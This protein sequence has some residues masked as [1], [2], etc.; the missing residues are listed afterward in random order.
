M[1]DYTQLDDFLFEIG[2]PDE[3]P[4][5]SRA[6]AS[7]FFV[8]LKKF[9]QE[10]VAAPDV[11][12]QLEGQFAVPLDQAVQ[13]IAQVISHELKMHAAYLYYS[14][15]VRS[16]AHRSLE[17]LFLQHA[18]GELRDAEYLLRRLG[19]LVPGGVPLP[20]PP[21]PEP[22]VD[23]AEILQVLISYEQQ[24]IA[25]LRML[26]GAMGGNPMKYTIE[27]M[28]HEE[29]EHLDRLWQHM[30]TV[31][32]VPEPKL[33]SAMRLAR[34]KLAN[35]IPVPPVGTEPAEQVIMREQQLALREAQGQLQHQ[36]MRAQ[37]L[38]Q[39]TLMAQQQAE[40][41]GAEAQNAQQQMQMAQQQAQQ[42]QQEAE[43]AG[44]QAQQA[45]EQAAG[46]Q[47]NA[48]QQAD[49]KMRLAMRIQQFR[50]Q[51]ADIV[52]Q[53]P[54]MEEGLGF[55]EQAGPGAP[56]TTAQQQ[57][58]AAQQQQEQQ[59]ALAQKPPTPREAAREKEEA[60]RAQQQAQQ[61]AEQA[62]AVE[63]AAQGGGQ[64]MGQEAAP[65]GAA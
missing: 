21:M 61:Q 15:M 49:A 54:V 53:D 30:P 24:A 25:L 47:E 42:A 16:P 2:Q 59:Q 18:E 32:S 52:A 23:P 9:A 22:L 17:K 10:E 31:Q 60:A 65:G 27:Q 48:A 12:G 37:H 26:H 5:L 3:G 33:A 28:L 57:Q 29:Q 58:Q 40:S 45:M 8:G 11:S 6:E 35:L 4:G 51:L 46:S 64:E 20:V 55:G 7:L 19:V 36:A 62:Q 14:Q 41:A 63:A 50:Q 44:Q 43:Q 39:Q 1:T 38:E 56:T 13:M 34:R